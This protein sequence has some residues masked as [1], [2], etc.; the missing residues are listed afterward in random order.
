V[1]LIIGGI[2]TMGLI[3]D[4]MGLKGTFWGW[5][6]SLNNNFGTL[7]FIVIGVFVVSWIVSIAIYRMN[8]Y[9][10]IEVST[11]PVV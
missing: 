4:Q 7:G 5:M 11:G 3:G 1:A 6:D 2:E 10:E 9:D 8:R